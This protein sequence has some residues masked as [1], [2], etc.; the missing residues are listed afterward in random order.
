MTALLQSCHKTELFECPFSRPLQ[1]NLA[2]SL[3]ET[4]QSSISSSTLPDSRHFGIALHGSKTVPQRIN[5]RRRRSRA[6]PQR[7]QLLLA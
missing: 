3:A 4:K 5:L 2:M 6:Y 7:E 1:T